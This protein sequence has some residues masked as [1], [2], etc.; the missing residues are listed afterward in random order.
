MRITKKV[1]ALRLQ[2]LFPISLEGNISFV[3]TFYTES[4]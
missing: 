1:S 4:F 3:T 2:E